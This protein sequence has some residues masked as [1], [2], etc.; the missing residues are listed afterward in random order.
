MRKKKSC[1]RFFPNRF[2][3]KIVLSPCAPRRYHAFISIRSLTLRIPPSSILLIQRSSFYTLD[4]LRLFRGSALLSDLSRYFKERNKRLRSEGFELNVSSR[5]QP[6][7]LSAFFA[8]AL[9]S[10][11]DCIF[12]PYQ[13]FYFIERSLGAF[14]PSFLPSWRFHLHPFALPSTIRARIRPP[15]L[16]PFPGNPPYL[17][18]SLCPPLCYRHH[19]PE[20]PGPL[21]SYDVP[22][23]R[24][25]VLFRVSNFKC[26]YSSFRETSS[27]ILDLCRRIF[28]V[29][30]V[31]GS[32]FFFFRLSTFAMLRG[33]YTR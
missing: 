18:Q 25:I 19:P 29:R 12:V 16:S 20:A 9:H 2:S 14:V 24:D 1:T 10:F 5:A 31:P 33:S 30:R 21:F 26:Y 23:V 3:T 27:R 28:P 8:R 22:F 7:Q 11:L 6:N 32:F 13:I 15:P 4:H 17:L